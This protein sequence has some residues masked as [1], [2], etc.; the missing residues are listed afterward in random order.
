MIDSEDK[1]LL[2]KFRKEDSRNYAFNLIVRK[3]QQKLY[4]HIRRMVIN[5]D[6]ADDIVQ[7]VFIKVWEHLDGFNESSQLYTW[8]YRIATNEC[9]TFL[10]KKR[11]RFFIPLVDVEANLSKSLEDDNYYDGDEVT[12]KL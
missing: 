3:Y 8:L 12:L 11:K 1:E 9:L 6:D 10:S 5:H 4:F 2:E 7:D